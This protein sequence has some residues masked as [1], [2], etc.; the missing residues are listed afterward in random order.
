M[1]RT[2]SFSS[3]SYSF[4]SFSSSSSSPLLAIY[5]RSCFPLIFLLLPYYFF[6]SFSI[7]LFTPLLLSPFPL[8]FPLCSFS[9]LPRF[10]PSL[11]R[12]QIISPPLS[13]SASAAPLLPMPLSSSFS[14]CSSSPLLTD[15]HSHYTLHA[16]NATI[17]SST[18]SFSPFSTSS[19]LFVV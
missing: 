8:P 15:S 1:L 5:P 16:G 18:S 9:S 2:Y 6:H 14:S 7:Y 19:V 4:S 3:F 10:P 13:I 12:L 11:R 17:S